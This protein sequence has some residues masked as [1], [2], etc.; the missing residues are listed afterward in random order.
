TVRTRKA[1]APSAE[2]VEWTSEGAGE[3]TIE[4]VELAGRGTE[5]VLHLREGE[6]EFLNGYRLRSIIESYSDH[7]SLPIIMPV[8]SSPTPAEEDD[9]Q[10]PSEPAPTEETVNRA[11][12][13]WTRAKNEIT[14]EEYNE[15]YKHISR[16]FED[17][18][19][20]I[21][22]RVEGNL[23]YTSLLYIPARAP[24]DLWDRQGRRGVKLYVRRVFIMDDADE[25]LPPYLRF[26]RGVI[27]CNDLPL[28]VS[29]EILQNDRKM[30][31]IRAGC[32]RR[33]LSQL[34]KMATSDEER[35]AKFW[36]EFGRVL[37]EG[38]IEDAKSRDDVAKLLRFNS[39]RTEDE[40]PSCSLDAYCEGMV[41]GQEHIYYITAGT[42]STARNSPHLEIFAKKG[43]EVLLLTD[44]VDEWVV[45]HLTEFNGKQLKSVAKGEL[46]LDAL[47]EEAKDEEKEQEQSEEHKVLVEHIEKAL[48]ER[49]K[50]ARV[51]NRLTTSP[52]CLVAD[53]HDMGAQLERIL[54][55]AGQ[56]FA[57]SK[58]ILEINPEHP[59]VRR[60]QAGSDDP[61]FDDWAHI[62]HDQALLSEG[63]KLEDPASFVRRLNEMFQSLAGV[64]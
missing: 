18:L 7:I 59:I 50:Q 54:S 4:S 48:G 14:D 20:T 43:I 34:Q 46:D 27:D 24:F 15:F 22:A 11:T 30:E 42:L 64:P 63:G 61:Q 53:E 23:E 5:I 25:L 19:E 44:E 47:G 17:P 41:E 35:Y 13:L 45:N 21:H 37:K 52:A 29:R 16:D 55:A 38:I 56:K 51:T 1:G 39:T 62:L 6:D 40:T 10:S 36:A 33:V 31:S 26:V 60:M 12:A 9:A 58:P 49:I 8:E 32:T 57:G 2:G 28:N 3:F